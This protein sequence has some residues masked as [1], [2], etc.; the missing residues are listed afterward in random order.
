M[1]AE[2]NRT[3]LNLAYNN[4]SSSNDDEDE[5]E[6]QVQRS[7]VTFKQ[8]QTKRTTASGLTE[9]GP[10]SDQSSAVASFRSQSEVHSELQRQQAVPFP[11]NST[12][13]EQFEF[14]VSTATDAMTL[15][16]STFTI[17]FSTS[18]LHTS[19]RVT[20]Y[21]SMLGGVE[22]SSTS[23][24]EMNIAE[25][26]DR[27][28]AAVASPQKVDP[29]QRD[30]Q[31]EII[32]PH[33]KSH[34]ISSD[35]FHST[36][37]MSNVEQYMPLPSR[38]RF[39]DPALSF[40]DE[41]DQ[42]DFRVPSI[43][44]SAWETYEQNDPKFKSHRR[45]QNF[46]PPHADFTAPARS[47]Y[48]AAAPQAIAFKLGEES[49]DFDNNLRRDIQDVVD[50]VAAST[51]TRKIVSNRQSLPIAVHQPLRPAARNIVLQ[52]REASAAEIESAETDRARS[53]IHV[54]YKRFNEL[55]EYCETYGDCNVPQKYPPNAQLGIVRIL[56]IGISLFLSLSL[57]F[58]T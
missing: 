15:P 43:I 51:R 20:E 39:I 35:P 29:E 40:D 54:W 44:P 47:S 55:I 6:G 41:Y 49:P 30:L 28:P 48:F 9:Q 24:L 17:D 26:D 56:F 34:S 14:E 18:P 33:R 57:S 52:R 37:T 25:E 7:N 16:E 2:W 36:Y 38:E 10:P 31:S 27:K 42:R 11:F 45:R 12:E 46:T 22:E 32:S 8:N 4:S 21:A 13:S 53:A 58:G 23:Q 3:S 5:L 1:A 19:S 50:S